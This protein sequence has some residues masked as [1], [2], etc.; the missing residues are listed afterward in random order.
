MRHH[1][2]KIMYGIHDWLTDVT[3]YV[4]IYIMLM[5]TINIYVYIHIYIYTYFIEP[6][7]TTYT[8]VFLVLLQREIP[9]YYEIYLW[10]QWAIS[11]LSLFLLRRWKFACYAWYVI[12]PSRALYRQRITRV[13]HK[14]SVLFWPMTIDSPRYI[15]HT[16][17]S[18]LGGKSSDYLLGQ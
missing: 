7:T 2:Y 18:F 12:L 8:L 6:Y 10:P 17:A 5:W 14:A 13:K 9:H 3:R 1:W 15:V 11:F 16:L 4:Q